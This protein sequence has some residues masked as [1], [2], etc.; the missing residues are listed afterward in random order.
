MR[1]PNAAWV[2]KL[3]DTGSEQ[4]D[5]DRVVFLLNVL[6]AIGDR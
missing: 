6:R 1:T 5:E 2:G 4:W 3:S